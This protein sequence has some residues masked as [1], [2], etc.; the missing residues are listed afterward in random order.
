MTSD[1]FQISNDFYVLSNKFQVICEDVL[2]EK[3]KEGNVR[4]TMTF[5]EY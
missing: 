5:G 1:L 4:E 2:C 3:V